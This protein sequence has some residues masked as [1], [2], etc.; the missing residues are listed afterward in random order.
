MGES[1]AG[2]EDSQ[3]R[4]LV[5]SAGAAP[6]SAEAAPSIEA[7]FREERG[8]LL[9]ALVHRFGDLDLAEEVASEAVEAALTHWPVDGV[10]R[11]PGAWLLTTARRKAVDRLR[12]DTAYAARLAILQ[13]EADRA[14]PSPP[15]DAD[16]D[17][18]DERLQLF[19]TCA[20]PALPAEDRGALTLRC[21][22]GLTTAE[23]ARAFLIPTATMAQRIVRVKRKIRQARI[24]FR[25]PGPDEL[26]ERLP[27]VLQVLYSLFTEGYAA[28]SGQTLQRLDIAEEA[29]RLTRILHRLLPGEREVAGLLALLLSTHARRDARTGGDGEIRLLDEQDR[30][31]WD[32]AMI[33]EG[34]ALVVTALTGGP[35]GPYGVQAAIAALHAEAEDVISTDWPQIVALYDVLLR[36][37]PSPVVALNRA[38]AVAMRDGPEAGLTLLATLADDPRLR[39]YS[40]YPTA[41]GDLLC[42][43]DR[44]A[45]AATAYRDALA[46]AHTEPER[47]HLRRRLTSAEH[48]CRGSH[49]IEP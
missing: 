38:V 7:A 37:T 3:A 1:D 4:P 10:P 20:H 41:R 33:E 27:G 17:L 21:L 46:L 15:A 13:V 22:A 29:L 32:R 2:A 48:R 9:A 30:S 45:E 18:P 34:R 25:V 6:A 28:S 26:S 49:R 42:R 36:L 23:V 47:A 39:D 8:R 16:G 24:P 40:P 35:P 12:R 43:L 31:R 19:F 14:D 11:S 44:F 5:G